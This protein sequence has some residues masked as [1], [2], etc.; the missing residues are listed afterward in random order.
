M[1]EREQ[2]INFL[3]QSCDAKSRLIE[4]LQKQVTELQKQLE[5]P[6]VVESETKN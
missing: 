5:P 1:N 2:M 3:L 6:P 4:E